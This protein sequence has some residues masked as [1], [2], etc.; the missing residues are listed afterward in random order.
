[1]EKIKGISV[2]VLPTIILFVALYTGIAG[3]SSVPDWISNLA[4][5]LSAITAYFLFLKENSIKVFLYWNKMKGYFKKDTVAWVGTY[6]F[7]F[8][9][10][11][12]NFK[13]DVYFLIERIKITFDENVSVKFIDNDNENYATFTLM[14][15][16][17]N[18]IIRV[19]YNQ[20][21]DENVHKMTISYEVS[22]S[23]SDSRTEIN[24]YNTFLD[25]LNKNHKVIGI[26][27]V[28]ENSEKEI[29]AV[30][31]SFYKYNPFYG[32]TIKHIDE[33]AKSV[34]FNL[35]F[36]MENMNI[37]TTKNTLKAVSTNKEQLINVLRDY[38]AISTI[39]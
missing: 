2:F 39:G 16:G 20:S 4:S 8:Y 32:L 33:R 24:R 38:V 6:K 12:Y 11:E 3:S 36:E 26:E 35:K 25:L 34:K 10:E 22:I 31:L 19:Y 7:S 14:L 30:K 21:L 37:T 1:M 27:A 29:Y 23:Y 17:Y 13:D 5:I 28:T 15:N 9:D 18:R